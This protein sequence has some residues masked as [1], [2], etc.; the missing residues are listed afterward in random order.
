MPFL[1]FCLFVCLFVCIADNPEPTDA[2]LC[3]TFDLRAC[4][5]T[6]LHCGPIGL[7]RKFIS[8]G[9]LRLP[10]VA[11]STP[12]M[13][14]SARHNLCEKGEETPYRGAP[15]YMNEGVRAGFSPLGMH[16]K[17]RGAVL[18]GLVPN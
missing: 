7:Q 17:T 12:D 4:V 3:L 13:T 10:K 9:R 1:K 14:I 18:W 15:L 5:P 6:R 8:R 11:S 16:S 2:I